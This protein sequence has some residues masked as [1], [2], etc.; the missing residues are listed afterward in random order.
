MKERK[1]YR[2]VAHMLVVILI[3]GLLASVPLVAFAAD[4]G[5]RVVTIGTDNG[6]AGGTASVVVT[7]D[8][9]SYGQATATLTVSY[10]TT[11]LTSTALTAGTVMP[12]GGTGGIGTGTLIIGF[13]N[14][15]ATST[16][17]GI[18]VTIDFDIDA[19]APAGNVPIS[20]TITASRP[21]PG[22]FPPILAVGPTFTINSGYVAISDAPI[23][24][25]GLIRVSPAT[26]P[27]ELVA[28]DPPNNT[29]D[30]A[31]AIY[32]ANFDTGLAGYSIVW[33]S[34]GPTVATVVG[35][36]TAPSLTA[37]VTGVAT[38][39][40]TVTAQLMYDGANVGTPVSFSIEVT[41][42]APGAINF[43]NA[44]GNPVASLALS[45]V[46]S[47]TFENSVVIRNTGDVTLTGVTAALTGAPAWLSVSAGGASGDLAANASREVI[48]TATNPPTYGTFSA[49][50]V[51]AN[52]GGNLNTLPV[53]ITVDELGLGVTVSTAAAW[54][55]QRISVQ[56]GN[57][58]G[59]NVTGAWLVV[60]SGAAGPAGPTMYVVQLPAITTA[61]HVQQT[62]LYVDSG[63][64]VT[65]FV[66]SQ[67]PPAGA[68]IDTAHL[69]APPDGY[70][71]G[72][73]GVHVVN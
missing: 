15:G 59:D 26:D 46:E 19:N 13:D 10:D 20:A 67:M 38:G 64:E 8:E 5:A 25:E 52:A 69:A 43:E 2:I 21:N 14:A 72:T 66:V 30:L 37:A 12:F 70:R 58:T 68:A 31:V 62:N 57:D 4:G 23:P 28:N 22:A 73:S 61:G 17:S 6:L 49:S 63:T 18:L 60:F 48:V 3:V 1:K 71:L 35:T 56:I 27:I 16:A 44:A 41:E 36:G 45:G 53:T 11:Y 40:T 24:P 42:L 54:G 32:P 47:S 33:T 50:L 65:A 29:A 9:A 39:S 7:L 34:A 51:I 55:R